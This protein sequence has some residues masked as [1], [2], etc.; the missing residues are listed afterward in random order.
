[1]WVVAHPLIEDWM[2]ENRGPQARLRQLAEDAA[3]A[4]ASLPEVARLARRAS[5]V[6]TEDGLRLHPETVRALERRNG[7]GP[8]RG[9]L[10]AIAGLAAGLLLGLLW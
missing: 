1:M 10:L 9:W 3:Q 6:V 8:A 2:M 7:G 5:L 4:A